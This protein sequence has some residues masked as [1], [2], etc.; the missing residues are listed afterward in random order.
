MDRSR[1]HLGSIIVSAPML[2]AIV[3]PYLAH[4]TSELMVAALVDASNRLL[5][6]VKA[7]EGNHHE[8]LL[9]THA[10]V[11]AVAYTNACGFLLAHNHP[12]GV[13]RPSTPDRLLTERMKLL[14][15]AM[16]C[17]LMDHLILSADGS[18][19]FSFQADHLL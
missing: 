7:G 8:V 16:G 10:L 1:L 9:D 17:Q 4:Q 19:W 5:G 13:V 15:D 6:V 14:G 18:E 3:R 2:A 12:S 11:R